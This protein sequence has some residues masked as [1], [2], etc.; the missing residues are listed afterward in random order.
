MLIKKRILSI[1]VS[2]G[3]HQDF[4]DSIFKYAENKQS[5]YVCFANVHMLVEAY[6]SPAFSTVVNSADIVAPDGLPVAKSFSLLYNTSQKRIDGTSIMKKVM[7]DCA[8]NGKK[9]FFYGGTQEML[10]KTTPYLQSNYPGLNVSG[11]YAPPFRVLSKE[12]KE[13]VVEQIKASGAV[14]VFVVLGCPKQESWMHEMKGKIPAVMLGIGGALPMM[15][16]IQKRA[17]LWVQKAG[18]E[19]FYRFSQEPKRLFHR[20]AS[21]NSTFIYLLVSEMIR[22]KIFKLNPSLA[23]NAA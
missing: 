22:T 19:W 11:M 4:V 10:D 20:Y 23:A 7:R 5:A 6:N 16:G 17:P 14:I 15:L 1:N 2:N 3:S 8:V 13:G 21:T 9:V 18:M 12:E